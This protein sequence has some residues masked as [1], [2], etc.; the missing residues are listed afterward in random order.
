[1]PSTKGPGGAECEPVCAQVDK[2]ANGILAC[3]KNIVTSRTRLYLALVMLYLK[4]SVQFQ[5]CHYK[6]DIE[7]LDCAQ[8]RATE[9]DLEHKS[10]G[11]Q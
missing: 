4:P 7:A 8:G 1:M 3:S 5:A 10:H 6:K 11:E 9:L 2:K